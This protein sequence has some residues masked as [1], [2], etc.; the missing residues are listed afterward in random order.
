MDR[1]ER[2]RQVVDQ[3]LCG[4]PDEEERR[5]G[6]VHLYGVA[7]AAALLALVRGLDPELATVA[8]MLHDLWTYHSGDPTDHGRRGA[9]LARE[10]LT[11]LDAFTADEITTLCAAVAHHCLKGEVH[12]AYDELL[13]DADV[14][15][16]HLYNTQFDVQENERPR[17]EA[18]YGELG[19]QARRKN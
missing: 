3:I 11:D 4:Q 6:F 18:L 17:L 12:G 10:I 19:A 14:L 15:Q 7:Q 5:C 13:K 16:H 9:L 8:G 1:T 2:V